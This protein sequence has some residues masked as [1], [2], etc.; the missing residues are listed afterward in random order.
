MSTKP[1]A[2]PS[3]YYL[4][5]R[6]GSVIGVI[7]DSGKRVNDY[8]YTPFGDYAGGD[9]ANASAVCRGC[10]GGSLVSGSMG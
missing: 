6:L 7:N 2:V 9:P 4:T 5:D 1:A 8:W 3:Y 10:R